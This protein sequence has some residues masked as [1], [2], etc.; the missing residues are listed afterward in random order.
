MRFEISPIAARTPNSVLVASVSVPAGEPADICAGELEKIDL[1]EL[2]TGG[3]D[4]VYLIRVVGDSM[5]TEIRNG[6]LIVVNKNLQAGDGDK[7]IA[8]VNGSF[9]VKTFSDCRK[10]L[11]LVASNGKYTPTEITRRDD[12]QIFGVV[13]HVIHNLKK[14]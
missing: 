5:E 4:G 9:T 12:F 6:D 2:I 14:I 1:N 10:R 7:V 8:S 3:S 11:R 13:T